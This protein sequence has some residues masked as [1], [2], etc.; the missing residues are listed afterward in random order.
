MKKSYNGFM[1]FKVQKV[2]IIAVA[3]L[4]FYVLLFGFFQFDIGIAQNGKMVNCPFSSHSMSICKMNPLEHLEEWQSMF[5]T[6]PARDTLL[7]L[8]VLLSVLALLRLK[9]LRKFSLHHQSHTISYI[10]PF[11][12]QRL[13]IPHP[14]KIAFSRGI[15]NPKTF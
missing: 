11:Y 7:F 9:F 13:F 1:L 2:I 5:T 10:D 14:L 6:L 8:T 4:A 12:F 3:I 15:L